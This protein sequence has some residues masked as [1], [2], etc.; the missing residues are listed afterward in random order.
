MFLIRWLRSKIG[1]KLL[2]YMTG[3]LVGTLITL[4]YIGTRQVKTFGEYA[5]SANEAGIKENTSA[6]LERITHEQAARYEKTFQNISAAAG[7]MASHAAFLLDNE[8]MFGEKS[9][10]PADTLIRCPAN[11]IFTNSASATAMVNYWGSLELDENISTLHNCLSYLDPVLQNIQQRLPESVAAFIITENGMQRYFPNIAK[12]PDLPPAAEY[13]M[14]YENYYIS[15]GPIMN[16][17]KKTIWT[18]IYQDTAGHGLVIT[19]ASPVYTSDGTFR[20]TIGIDVT[21]QSI[22]DEIL[23][24][25]KR[26]DHKGLEYMVPFLVDDV[27]VIIAM[28]QPYLE[29]LGLRLHD[30]QLLLPGVVLVHS[31]L[32]S[33]Y[34]EIRDLGKQILTKE[35]QSSRVVLDENA[36]ILASHS[37]P[38]TG[39]RFCFLIPEESLLRSVIDTK[40]KLG[41]TVKKLTGNFILVTLWAFLAALI[42]ASLLLRNF[43]NPM[44]KLTDATARVRDG[45][46]DTRIHLKRNDEIGLMGNAF[47]EMVAGLAKARQAEERYT[48]RLESEV[49]DRTREITDKNLQLEQT[50]KD[51]EAE[52][53]NRRR[54]ED[55]LR[56]ANKMLRNREHE[57]KASE[58]DLRE[59]NEF[60]ENVFET[61]G[62][63]IFITD[64]E[65]RIIRVNRLGA[66]MIGYEEG[67]LIGRHMTEITGRPGGDTGS[68]PPIIEQLLRKGTIEGFETHLVK[69]DGSAAPVEI[70]ANILRNSN[71]AMTGA[72]CS[73]RDITERLRAEEERTRLISAVE[74]AS[75]LIV[76]MGPDGTL[77]YMNPTISKLTGYS[78]E[79]S[80]GTNPFAEGGGLYDRNYY[81]EIWDTINRGQMWKGQMTM[82]KSDGGA[83]EIEMTISPIRDR[84]GK[85]I[86]FVSISRDVSNEIKMQQ[87]LR[88]AQKMEAIGTLAGGIAHDFNN[89]LAVVM[90][91]L[92]MSIE[93]VDS[94]SQLYRNLKQVLS[95][96]D[97][98][99]NLIEQILTFS[100][101]TEQDKKPI[102][103][104]PVIK[105][106]I[107]FLR[108]SLPATIT[109]QQNL[110]AE[111]DIVMSD[112]TQLQ[113][114]VM[115]LC[116]NAKHAMQETGGV[117]EI[118]TSEE[119]LDIEEAIEHSNISPGRYIKLSIRDT[120]CG[121]E[122]SVLD[123][124]FD[125]FFTTKAPGEG[126]GLG[127]SVVHGII[128]SYHGSIRAFSTPGKGT[129]F[130]LYLPLVETEKPQAGSDVQ[131]EVHGGTEKILVVDDEQQ[132]VIMMQQMLETLGYSVTART[133]SIEALECFQ[134]HPEKYDLV[135]TDQT[136]PNMTGAEL[137][138]RLLAIRPDIPIVLCTG[139]SEVINEIAAKSLGIREYML[140]PIIRADLAKAIRRALERT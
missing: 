55:N 73:V 59:S 51:L 71:D 33:A 75:E 136:M 20:G 100:R 68:M 4:S 108:A 131:E 122:Q 38:S 90:G 29:K 74:Q 69:R 41:A 116:T 104:S 125:P 18:S 42:F 103:I 27:G 128:K 11:E 139:Y 37:M 124:I 77:Q 106:T 3:I 40:E 83:C 99:Q 80:V 109:M 82:K 72:V 60:I 84:F 95:A 43:I 56:E 52:V 63:G 89:I 5:A 92:E 115:N 49:Q 62:D 81:K 86:S 96:A 79:K 117:I 130:D 25:N 121:M 123:K 110:T 70:N 23:S 137:A 30:D 129:R 111:N 12:G 112:P 6:F 91:Y 7:F 8:A 64:T 15:A 135:I 57:L 78:P 138:K 101:Q 26:H 102:S 2:L 17:E 19:A 53:E 35:Y 88:Q 140:K 21:L 94:S 28:Q 107:K 39:W 50:L 1:I 113:Q 133:S 9:R 44:K 16:P 58:N 66:A 87:E 65:G 32:D 13:D 97:R 45:D 34:K 127:L 54:T 22:V 47:N 46:L 10:N 76:L 105:E 24:D 118:S 134:G 36:Y 61:A 114:I 132:I 48:Q 67:E 119:F 93:M 126:T 120:G 98:A 85:I 14:R 31:L